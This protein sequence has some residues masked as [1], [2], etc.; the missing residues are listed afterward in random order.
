MKKYLA[1]GVLIAGV[2]LLYAYSKGYLAKFG[3][4]PPSA[5]STSQPVNVSVQAT[6]PA[7]TVV[8]STGQTAP[9]PAPAPQVLTPTQEFSQK[10][11]DA[12]SS[13]TAFDMVKQAR[14]EGNYDYSILAS[15]VGKAEREAQATGSSSSTG[16][17]QASE[18]VIIDPLGNQHCYGYTI[19]NG[20]KVYPYIVVN[21]QLVANPKYFN[22]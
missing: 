2:G 14:A 17:I 6:A 4:L 13:S 21:G 22:R 1:L 19:I 12:P 15:A 10:V 16:W 20:E 8:V 9:T 5:Q 18:G 7:P 11:Y 3:L